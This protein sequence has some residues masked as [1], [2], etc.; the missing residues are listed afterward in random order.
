MTRP[1]WAVVDG[2]ERQP[3]GLGA[4]GPGQAFQYA[5]ASFGAVLNRTAVE[6]SHDV[7]RLVHEIVGSQPS[8]NRRSALQAVI[9]VTVSIRRTLVAPAVPEALAIRHINTVG[10]AVAV[11]LL[12][13][14]V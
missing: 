12:I 4:F 5:H 7:G 3:I 2:V 13:H 11:A 14:L 8:C 9:I 1:S 10:G 6:P